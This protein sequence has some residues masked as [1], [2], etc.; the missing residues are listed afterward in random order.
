MIFS[1]FTKGYC[2]FRYNVCNF[3]NILLKTNL[4]FSRITICIEGIK[5]IGEII[6]LQ[7]FLATLQEV[8]NSI[9]NNICNIKNFI[10]IYNLWFDIITNRV[11]LLRKDDKIT[12]YVSRY[13]RILRA[14]YYLLY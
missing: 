2:E 8:T 7:F 12:T 13:V 14:F 3:R 1:N 6:Q 10:L 5:N 9:T 11:G 4:E